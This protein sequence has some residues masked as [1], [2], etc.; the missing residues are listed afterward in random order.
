MPSKIGLYLLETCVAICL[1]YD[2][3]RFW[4]NRGDETISVQFLEQ[5]RENPMLAAAAGGLLVHLCGGVA[6][7]GVREVY[8]RYKE[9]N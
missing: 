3:I 7:V 6:T 2:G 9:G 5:A 1:V 4:Q 8:K